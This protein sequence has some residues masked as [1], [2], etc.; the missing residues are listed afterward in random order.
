MFALIHYLPFLSQEHT[1]MKYGSPFSLHRHSVDHLDQT[2]L[3]LHMY[4]TNPQ[5]QI[6]AQL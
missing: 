3:S 6:L 1:V 5:T 2:L 4:E